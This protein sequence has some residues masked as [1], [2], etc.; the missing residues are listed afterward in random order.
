MG[1]GPEEDIVEIRLDLDVGR[2]DAGTSA[3]EVLNAVG[4]GPTRGLSESRSFTR[5]I[6]CK[7]I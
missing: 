2:Q 7:T 6:S 3:V 1:I 4:A 5:P